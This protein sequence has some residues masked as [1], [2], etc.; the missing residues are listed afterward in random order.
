MSTTVNLGSQRKYHSTDCCPRQK[1]AACHTQICLN[2]LHHPAPVLQCPCSLLLILEECGRHQVVSSSLQWLAVS[3]KGN[4]YDYYT[5]QGPMMSSASP[6]CTGKGFL[7]FFLVRVDASC[8]TRPRRRDVPATENP[9]SR[10]LLTLLP[11]LLRTGPTDRAV[12]GYVWD[13][14]TKWLQ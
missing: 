5:P 6:L 1:Q 3:R 9:P 8:A 13:T 14:G 12:G 7:S 10:P 4:A 11:P 2:W